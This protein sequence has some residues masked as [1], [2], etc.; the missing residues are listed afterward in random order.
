MNA[1]DPQ[2]PT[3]A[4]VIGAS[5]GAI[6]A[7]LSI[8]PMLPAHYPF[9][10]LVVVHVPPD[11]KSA[12]A[13]LFAPRCKIAV[14]EADDKE[15]LCAGTLYF[16]PADYH[17]LVEPDFTISLSN[18][19]PV[20]FS[21][22][23]IDV[24]FQSAADAFGSDLTGVILTGAS[25]DGALGLQAI[26]ANGGCALIQD[27]NTAEGETMPRAAIASCPNARVLRL[28]EVASFLNS[29]SMLMPR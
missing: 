5:V 7:L 19:E 12:L 28:E 23:A 24:L 25:S 6:E 2:P 14:K 13:E 29:E 9:P 15:V 18:D 10:V 17:L 21:R 4:V 26:C 11:R 27:P 22:P 16:A 20:H 8:L 3:A 1:P